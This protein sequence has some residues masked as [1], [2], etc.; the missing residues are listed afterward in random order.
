MN[1]TATLIALQQAEVIRIG[2]DGRLRAEH[3]RHAV[4]VIDPGGMVPITTTVQLTESQYADLV[5]QW[6]AAGAPASVLQTRPDPVPQ[7]IQRSSA[8]PLHTPS[9]I[10]VPDTRPAAAP[11]VT[12][13]FA[14]R[15]SDDLPPDDD[16][17]D[18]YAYDPPDDDDDDDSGDG[19]GA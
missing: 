11:Q 9:R 18:D 7:V 1:S 16:D 8:P 2:D 10:L 12:S 13:P 14:T 15:D 17:E 19:W 5:R 6:E 4:Y 3:T